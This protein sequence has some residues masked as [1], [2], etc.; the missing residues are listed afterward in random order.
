MFSDPVL[1]QAAGGV[2]ASVI[3][4]TATRLGVTL[5]SLGSRGL[6]E[7]EE[8]VK[9]FN[10]YTV[11]E[12]APRISTLPTGVP[13]SE[14]CRILESS[15]FHS[16]IHELLAARLTD[17][18]EADVQDIRKVFELTLGYANP[19]VDISDF[20]D[21]LFDYY[22]AE[23][24]SIVGRIQGASPEFLPR[25]RSEAFAARMVSS[26][27]ALERR[28]RSYDTADPQ[29]DRAFLLRYKNHLLEEFG[30]IEPPDFERR[31]RVPISDL[32]VTP[33]INQLDMPNASPIDV[34]ELGRRIDRTV[35]L[36]DPGGGKT[37]ASNVLMHWHANSNGQLTPFLVTLREFA[38]QDPPERSVLK[39]I[40]HT[41]E[42]IYQ[43]PPPEG[44]ISRLLLSGSALVIFDG[45]DELIDT[46][47]RSEV[48]TIVERFCTE[49]PM[50]KVLVTSR[51]VGY[52]QA[53]LDDQCFTRYRVGGFDTA[54][55]SEYV[56]KWFAQESGISNPEA[57]ALAEAFMSES[58]TVSDLRSNPLM[59]ALMCILY[60]GEGS[61][62]RNRPEVYEQ[63]AGLLFRKWD[64]RRRI[65]TE[66]RA[67]PHV[68]PALRH[69]AYWLFSRQDTE[70]AVTHGGLISE[71]AKFLHGRG[72]ES[73]D[74]AKE[75]AEEFVDFCKGRAW[76]FSDAGTTAR[77][78]ALYT[79]THRTFLEYFTAAYL[80]SVS[81]TPEKLAK[82]LVPH[83]AKEEWE[84]VAE[85]AVQMKDRSVD[86]GAARV[87][88]SLLSDRR[89]TAFDS[90]S[91]L[92]CFLA[93]CLESVDPPP[94]VVRE[95]TR[96][97]LSHL[98]RGSLNDQLFYA[99]LLV[100]VRCSGAYREIVASEITAKID[101]LAESSD[102]SMR[103]AGLRL[104]VWCDP[105]NSTYSR[106][107][108]GSIGEEIGRYWR[109]FTEANCVR[110][111]SEI[112][113]AAEADS[114]FLH[115][116][117][118]RRLIDLE[119]VLS[120]PHNFEKLT[121]GG[122]PIAIFG[123]IWSP[124]LPTQAI[125]LVTQPEDVAEDTLKDMAVVG[126]YVAQ[127]SSP[128]WMRSDSGHWAGFVR[129][130]VDPPTLQPLQSDAFLGASVLLMI[131]VELSGDVGFRSGTPEDLGFL[132]D[133]HPYLVT[134]VARQ[135]E[136]VLPPL[137]IP[138]ELQGLMER[139][140]LGEVDFL[141][142][143]A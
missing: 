54:R 19:A 121:I 24:S 25:L 137:P 31:R 90:R 62:P 116:A 86:Q 46:A 52:D 119:Q 76:V 56:R 110:F 78:E 109:D 99:P 79:F 3:G 27:K 22:D 125:K 21:A 48:T 141:R 2:I 98:L 132:S 112:V 17:A 91:N 7:D 6:K 64:A 36:G 47:R 4:A 105:Q 42:I 28:V 135:T 5:R 136:V 140:A 23:I 41:L 12:S 34:W 138:Q 117:L 75:A 26:L 38:S 65:H 49:Y 57:E 127:H 10:T 126:K 139:W 73:I 87:Y 95:L 60:R 107:P 37:T 111:E 14:L 18:P 67:R 1:Q 120:H 53:R 40:E 58:V 29:R 63:C 97:C 61:I 55:V 33:E 108:L 89:Y 80:S 77:G 16:V 15:A 88:R 81:D 142:S 72:F 94:A 143:N 124:Y 50:V 68:E 123:T 70:S 66:L 106:G 39:H 100:L 71:T 35:L 9:W 102:E 30:K 128:P 51:L 103:L 11:A 118:M 130:V 101:E 85:L 69:L 134:R 20:S 44:L 115:L 92:L 82:L 113:A 13:E 133:L 84:V 129:P 8:V 96:N 131:I 122:H 45:L 104:A 32:Y 83:V 93:A 74:E 59:L 43:C 114:G